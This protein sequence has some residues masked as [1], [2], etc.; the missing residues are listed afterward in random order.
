MKAKVTVKDA[1][2]GI[3]D[4]MGGQAHSLWDTSTLKYVSSGVR[5]AR[6]KKI[7]WAVVSAEGGLIL[8]SEGNEHSAASQ[9]T[10]RVEGE[11]GKRNYPNLYKDYILLM[12]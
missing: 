8:W 7:L 6:E 1:M 10:A 12:T 5:S 4:G 2:E 11:W 3:S 9:L